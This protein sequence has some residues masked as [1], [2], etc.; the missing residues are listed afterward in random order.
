MTSR[1]VLVVEDD[2]TINDALAQRLRAEGYVVEQA[3]DGP[4]AVEI[5]DSNGNSMKL[6]AAGITIQASSKI[7]ITAGRPR[8]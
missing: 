1:T 8:T 7:S 5:V 2:R 6:E 3:F 4:G